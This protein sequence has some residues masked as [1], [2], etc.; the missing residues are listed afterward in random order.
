MLNKAILEYKK[1]LAINPNY[2]DAH[3][4]LGTACLKKGIL[5]E[6]ISEFRKTL[7]IK[8]NHLETHIKLGIAYFKQGRLDDAISEFKKAI[9][10][11]PTLA[12]TYHKLASALET[13]GKLSDAISAYREVIHLKPDHHKAYNNLAWIYAT[14]SNANI[15]NGNE[16]IALATKACEL[17][18]F[19]KAEAL[20]TLAAAYAEQGNFDKA[21]EHQYKAIELAS[22]QIEEDLQKRLQLYK[23]GHA[24]QDQ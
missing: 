15:R 23:L 22:P 19:K 6:A 4:N 9:A 5:D 14:S 21:V 1:A 24:Y 10:I 11:N 2:A 18:G 17:T 12:E 16:A 3:I 8:P 13:Q 7:I 20:D